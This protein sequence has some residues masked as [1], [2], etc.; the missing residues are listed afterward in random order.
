MTTKPAKKVF[1][2]GRGRFTASP[3]SVKR[4]AEACQLRAKGMTYREIAERLNYGGADQA[5]RG[6]KRAMLAIVQEPAEEIRLLELERLNLLW[7][8]VSQI[9]H[10]SHILAQQGKIVEHDGTPLEDYEPKLK[11]VDRLLK[12][13]ERR[14]KLLGLD[15][16]KKVE[17]L[18]ID[19][20]DSE[21]KK[22]TQE[23]YE[24]E[25]VHGE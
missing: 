14:A 12:I 5:Y 15:A 21:I 1:H 8:K 23:L 16:P 7:W 2:D 10:T 19:L 17:L 4:D 6:V 3:E 20:I 18:S 22:L 13:Q 9:L 25:L 11:A 24:H